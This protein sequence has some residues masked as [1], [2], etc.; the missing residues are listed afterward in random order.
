MAGPAHAAGLNPL[1]AAA[2]LDLGRHAELRDSERI[3]GNLHRA[4]A[5][6]RGQPRGC[7]L[8]DAACFADMV[9]FNGGQPPRR[10]A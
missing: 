3:V 6:F 8:D 9:A 5:E 2:A 10:L 4:Y 7:P 1:Q